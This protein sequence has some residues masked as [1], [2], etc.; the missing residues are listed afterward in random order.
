MDVVFDMETGDPDDFLTLV[1]L[2]GHPRVN[3]VGVTV[4][5]G[6]PDQIGVVRRALDWFGRSIP[7]GSFNLAHRVSTPGNDRHGRRGA[8]VSSWHYAAF[9]DIPPS[10]DALPGP[11]LLR[12]LCG[13][14]TTLLTGAP[15][16]NLGAA[17]RLPGFELGQL[18]A[19]GGFAGD[20]VVP[21]DRQLAKFR[22]MVTCPSYNLNGDPASALAV[23]STA[24]IARKRFVSKNVC[25]GIVYDRT[26][27]ARVAAS[28]DR[29][30]SLDVI[31]RGMDH[32]LSGHAP[33]PALPRNAAIASAEVQVAGDDRTLTL[34]GLAEAIA[35]A[36]ARGLDLVAVNADARPPICRALPP[37]V[38]RQPAEGPPGKKLHDPFAACCAIDPSIAQWAEVDLYRA[39]GAWGS[40]PAPGSGVFITIGYD[41]AKFLATLLE[42]GES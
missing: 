30:R 34:T 6:T 35:A 29:S 10:W 25:H 42:S 13:P 26:L 38:E 23:M 11:E 9:G 5:P 28:R 37:V 1:L 32:Y 17:I 40:R 2:L 36:S 7:V 8:C 20:G 24:A 31:W 39:R 14:A 22:G 18:V 33:R 4:T 3:L 21:V 12:D 15:L 16:K 41:N 27:H 19:Q